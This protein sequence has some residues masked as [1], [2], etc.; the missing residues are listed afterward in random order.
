MADRIRGVVIALVVR[1]DDPEELGRVKVR[2]PWM[3]D[4]PESAWARVAAPMAGPETGFFFQPEP[5]EEHEALV[6]FEQGDPRRP[7]VV[8]WLW[9]GDQAPPADDAQQRIIKT[10]KGHTVTLDD[11]DGEEGITLEDSNGNKVVMNADGITIETSGDL[12]LKGTNVEI[13]ASAQ[14]T[15]KGNP[16]HLNP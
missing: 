11:R 13:E 12:I 9:N 6:A 14:L 16:I 3:K 7:Y 15:G 8:G 4:E 1:L 5:G 10:A 2:F